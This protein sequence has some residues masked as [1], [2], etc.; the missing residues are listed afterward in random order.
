M[1]VAFFSSKSYD[2]EYFNKIN[3][4]FNHLL[5][6]F[7]TRLNSHTVQLAKEHDAICAFVNDKVNAETLQAMEEQS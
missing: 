3:N 5:D 2:E 6:F 7:E 4:Q 1:K